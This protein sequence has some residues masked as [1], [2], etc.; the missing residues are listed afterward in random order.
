MHLFQQT[1]IA[2]RLHSPHCSTQ[3]ASSLVRDL[4]GCAI[5]RMLVTLCCCCYRQICHFH[6]LP[7]W[8]TSSTRRVHHVQVF[9]YQRCCA[10]ILARTPLTPKSRGNIPKLAGVDE[11]YLR[12]KNTTAAR[13]A[14]RGI[15]TGRGRGR[16]RYWGHV[17]IVDT[18]SNKEEMRACEV[19]A[20]SA[21]PRGC[22]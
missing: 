4:K 11:I 14:V 9:P 1:N 13:Q 3:P 16:G 21:R 5:L 8:A 15:G 19:S 2:R 10:Q 20:W 12:K 22:Y 6:R 7:E 18:H 17:T